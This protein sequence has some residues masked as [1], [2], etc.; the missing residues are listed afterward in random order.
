[1]K[2]LLAKVAAFFLILVFIIL[3]VLVWVVGTSSGSVWVIKQLDDFEPRLTMDYQS[4]DLWSGLQINS[5][6]WEGQYEFVQMK[7]IYSQWNLSCLLKNT[8]C[9][10]KL[11]ANHI[12]V[13]SDRPK[14]KKKQSDSAIL[15]PEI[16]L[17]VTIELDELKVDRLEIQSAGKQFDIDD[18]ALQAVVNND[19]LKI[20]NF[21]V[22]YQNYAAEIS[23]ALQLSGDYPLDVQ[24][25][26][27]A[28]QLLENQSETINLRLFNS[29]KE[30][31]F[32]GALSGVVA[33][34]F[35]GEA[36]PLD[37]NLPY[38]A[39]I[40]WQ[41]LNW[42]LDRQPIFRVHQGYLKV[43]GEKLDYKVKLNTK[44]EGK[45]TPESTIHASV[46][47]DEQQLKVTQLMVETLNGTVNIDGELSWEKQLV[48]DSSIQFSDIDPGVHWLDYPGE[49]KGGAELSGSINEGDLQLTVKDMFVDGELRGY[50]LK[51]RTDV[52]RTA[53]GH[54]VINDASLNMGENKVLAKGELTEKWN[55]SGNIHAPQL[56]VFLPE[57]SGQL[58]GA[59]SIFGDFEKPDIEAHL[60]GESIR[61]QGNS[62]GHLEL[63]AKIKSLAEN[64]SQLEL[65]VHEITTESTV[66]DQIN[67]QLKG[68]QKDH[69]LQ[70]AVES[71]DYQVDAA[72]TG[73]ILQQIE[74]NGVMTS[75]QIKS[76]GQHWN[77]VDSVE[78]SWHSET[79]LFNLEPHC[80]Q[81]KKAELCLLNQLTTSPD[82][83]ARIVLSHYELSELQENLPEKLMLTGV[84]NA[85]SHTIWGRG[86]SLTTT[87]Y[88]E[89]NDGGI[90]FEDDESGE[91]V[92]FKYQ[93]LTARADA[94]PEQFESKLT[95]LSRDLGNADMS[96]TLDPKKKNRPIAGSAQIDGLNIEFL[97]G[98]FPKLKTLAGIVNATGKIE[99]TLKKPAYVGKVA[100]ANLTIESPSLP[101]GVKNG[102]VEFDLDGDKGT[103]Q[104]AW[105]AGGGPVTLNGSADWS[106]ASFL[107]NLT[108][109]GEQLAVQYPP[110]IDVELSP[111][112][113]IDIGP[114]RIDI[115]GKIEIPQGRI[116][117]KELPENATSLSN[118][119]VIVDDHGQQETTDSAWTV[120][121]N[122]L[123]TLGHDVRLSGFGLRA[124]LAG[125]LRII[126]AKSGEP[127]VYGE[128]FV[129]EGTYKGYGQD[130]EAEGG[131]I[132]FVGPLDSTALEI[133]AV[134]KTDDVTAGLQIRGTIDQPDIS[135]FAEPP[136]SEEDTLAYI[137]LGRPTLRSEAEGSVL[138]SAALSLG[139]KGGRGIATKI[140]KK[141]GIREFEVEASEQ[142]GQSQVVFSGRLLPN[143][144]MRYGVGVFTPESTWTLRYDLTEKFY[145]ETIQGLES[146]LDIFYSFDFQS[147]RAAFESN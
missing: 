28:T 142:G 138:A 113:T 100:L 72:L 125:E 9:I 112:I 8:V 118:D 34:N 64:E 7:N 30:I 129:V 94:K 141:L 48:W 40:Q 68:T 62:I 90:E 78:L 81:Q 145:I 3:G 137:V 37:Q 130:L 110:V 103:F 45:N 93:Q 83:E 16:V 92:E 108:I 51:L 33:A 27:V 53:Q 79:G 24:V 131:R 127:D 97:R 25:Q 123:L 102:D 119:V 109:T 115:N 132:V 61:Y 22:G 134:R 54:I 85:Y 41:Q 52:K 89:V 135:L 143:L 20:H 59:F 38:F 87:L 71:K 26:L 84:M 29:V 106:S 82:D 11:N 31:E 96:L 60:K 10:K 139:V 63:Q 65:T 12:I 111:D 117:L 58:Q 44:V 69:L 50:P 18:I 114:Q 70:F 67:L 126:Q 107:A 17:P 144:T 77:L 88:A 13:R 105:Q 14:N 43:R 140:A 56:D 42:P 46:K 124:L 57:M 66:I 86:E 91:F 73:A 36:K 21:S 116:K 32:D 4:G 55:L 98:F 146:S 1:M 80:W 75:A 76:M 99:G 5:L 47:G 74:W 39:S 120:N 104:G 6:V 49:L 19:Q 2:R 133:D 23:G 128:I 15:L 101:I 35:N 95:L 136:Q 147:A 122:L 121:T